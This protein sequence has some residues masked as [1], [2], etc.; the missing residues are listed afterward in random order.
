[1]PCSFY[2]VWQILIVYSY[3]IYRQKADN[4]WIFYLHSFWS[5]LAP[6]PVRVEPAIKNGHQSLLDF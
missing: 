4:K 5:V 1:M 2:V 6:D 3:K